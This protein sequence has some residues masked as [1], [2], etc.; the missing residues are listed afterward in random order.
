MKLIEPT[1][2]QYFEHIQKT[3]A[4]LRECFKISELTKH[5]PSLINLQAKA[6]NEYRL[7]AVANLMREYNYLVEVHSEPQ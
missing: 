7:E 2:A 5:I 4:S 3:S 6:N 1:D